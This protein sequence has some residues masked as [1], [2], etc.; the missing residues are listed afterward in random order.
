MYRI[1]WEGNSEQAVP[2]QGAGPVVLETKID[3]ASGDGSTRVH[4]D[5]KVREYA[6]K[7]KKPLTHCLQ[8]STPA[9]EAAARA[10]CPDHTVQVVDADTLSYVSNCPT[11]QSTRTVKRIDDKTWTINTV[12]KVKV[13]PS[14]PFPP[15]T[16][17]A[18]W[19]RIADLCK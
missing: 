15:S 19:T 4:A 1:D 16:V 18:R 2:R 14:V 10:S 7:G 5:G 17:R 12:V 8:P 11:A 3:G 9:M 6:E 13:N